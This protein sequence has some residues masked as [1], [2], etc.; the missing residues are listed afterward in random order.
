[1]PDKAPDTQRGEV[2]PVGVRHPP[3]AGVI[4]FLPGMRKG[5]FFYP[6]LAF[7]TFTQEGD[8]K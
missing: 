2:T 7:N 5:L 6:E 3:K 4:L 8:L 1:M